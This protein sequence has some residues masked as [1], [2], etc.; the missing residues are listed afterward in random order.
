MFRAIALDIGAFEAIDIQSG[1]DIL[2]H[3]MN[4]IVVYPNP[5]NEKITVKSFENE[6][7]QVSITDI[8][9]KEQ[10]LIQ[11]NEMQ[12]EINI[13][14]LTAGIYFVKVIQNKKS[15]TQKLIINR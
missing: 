1:I 2:N 14:G 5:A 3:N 9:G 13:N 11:I 6:L 7:S 12:T 8:L 10:L 4:S 15:F